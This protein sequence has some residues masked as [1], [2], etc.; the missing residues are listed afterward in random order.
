MKMKKGMTIG[1]CFFVI[2][3]LISHATTIQA[4]NGKVVDKLSTRS[5]RIEDLENLESVLSNMDPDWFDLFFDLLFDLLFSEDFLDLFENMRDS[6]FDFILSDFEHTDLARQFFNV[7]DVFNIEKIIENIESI[8]RDHIIEDVQDL[9][10]IGDTL[11]DFT[12]L[13]EEKSNQ[14]AELSSLNEIDESEYPEISEKV[15]RIGEISQLWID[16]LEEWFDI[17]GYYIGCLI[18][19]VLF[20][21]FLIPCWFYV[22]WCELSQDDPD[23]VS[24]PFENLGEIVRRLFMDGYMS[25]ARKFIWNLI[26]VSSKSGGVLNFSEKAP[27][28]SPE[29]TE[30]S[31]TKNADI[32][33][34]V[35]ASDPDEMIYAGVHAYRDYVQV[36]FDWNN[37]S[38]VDYWSPL[39]GDLLYETKTIT[40]KH[41]FSSKGTY[42]VNV[43]VR[44][45]WGVNSNWKSIDVTVTGIKVYNKNIR[46]VI[47]NHILILQKI[48][49]YL[50]HNNLANGRSLI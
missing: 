27:K 22:A 28:C 34:T 46:G 26:L 36:G 18:T 1:F 37:D 5:I 6:V 15:K 11:A 48:F 10:L 4:S 31:G 2:F 21:L 29:K 23:L 33:F 9:I 41:S 12:K 19:V 38:D 50:N 47:S 16:P 24:E 35:Y 49:K 20:A 17:F 32:S 8:R 3:I 43:I 44:D 42:R 30:L 13:H 25:N 39:K 45:Q 14:A 40:E 7:D